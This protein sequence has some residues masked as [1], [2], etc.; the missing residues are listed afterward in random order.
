M[1]LAP[2]PDLTPAPRP[3]IEDE[4]KHTDDDDFEDDNHEEDQD[5]YGAVA[6][7]SAG[8]VGRDVGLNHRMKMDTLFGKDVF[9]VGDEWRF[10]FLVPTRTGNVLV[11]K[12]ATVSFHDYV[13]VN[14]RL[15]GYYQQG[16]RFGKRAWAG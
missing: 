2:G 12:D 10:S 16:D 3:A 14:R 8:S 15:T 4:E 9:K 7:A 13:P 1:S 5:G 6:S 11:E